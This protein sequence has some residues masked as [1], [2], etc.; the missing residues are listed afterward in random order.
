MPEDRDYDYV[1]GKLPRKDKSG[2]DASGDRIGKGGRHREDGTFSGMAYDLQVV[3][4]DPTKPVPAPPP[5]V[6]TRT[7]YVDRTPSLEEELIYMGVSKAVDF[8]LNKA[9]EGI[10]H[11]WNRHL[12]KKEEA[13]RQKILEQRRQAAERAKT[14]T[15]SP[16]ARSSAPSTQEQS[17]VVLPADFDGAYHDYTVDMTSEQAQKK[18]FEA[19]VFQYLCMKN[20]N[21]LAHARI[22]DTAGNVIEGRTVVAKLSNPDV[23]RS[24]NSLL[25][26]NPALLNEWQAK[27]LSDALG[28]ELVQDACFIPI[29]RRELIAPF[30]QQEQ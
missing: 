26:S 13:R 20:L 15:Q 19:F 11:L 2:K 10:R 23:V 9:E 5:R 4:S 29:Q 25:A 6:I 27:A 30:M 7:E 1:V 22:V 17:P 18:L 16:P 14:V 24:I 28:R 21:E 3:D 8:G 12:E